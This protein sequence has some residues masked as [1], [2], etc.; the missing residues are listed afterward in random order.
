M[1]FLVPKHTTNSFSAGKRSVKAVTS[2]KAVKLRS[3]KNIGCP[4][5]SDLLCG[6]PSSRRGQA[7]PRLPLL[8]LGVHAHDAPPCPRLRRCR[9]GGNGGEGRVNLLH[10]AYHRLAERLHPHFLDHEHHARLLAV[11]SGPQVSEGKEAFV[12]VCVCF[13]FFCR[14]GFWFFG[15]F[16]F[17]ICWVVGLGLGSKTFWLGSGFWVWFVCFHGFVF[18]FSFFL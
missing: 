10:V 9:Q 11:R 4:L 7:H 18:F 13:C 8:L 14:L 17:G 5:L 2:V 16:G 6:E 1:P 12:E 15:F 3:F